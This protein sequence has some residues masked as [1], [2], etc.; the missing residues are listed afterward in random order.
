MTR[1]QPDA[2]AKKQPDTAVKKQPDAGAKKKAFTSGAL[3]EARALIW[4]HR[5]RLGFG[6]ALMLINRLSGLVLPT[7]TKYLMDDVIRYFVV[8]GNT[9]PDSRLINISARPSDRRLR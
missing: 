4:S 6:L 3:E 2:A 9:R 8:V 1:P 5:K 7:T